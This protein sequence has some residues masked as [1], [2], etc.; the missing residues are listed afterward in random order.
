M[1]Y[2]LWDVLFIDFPF[3]DKRGTETRGERPAVVVQAQDTEE[4][5]TLIVVPL[6]EGEFPI[7]FKNCF[8]V[9]PTTTNGLRQKSCA[10]PFQLRSIDKK[11]ILKKVGILESHYYRKMIQALHNLFPTLDNQG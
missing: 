11:R 8:H 10:M 3:S 7:Q 9:F 5:P 6:T 2:Q 4:Y 1:S